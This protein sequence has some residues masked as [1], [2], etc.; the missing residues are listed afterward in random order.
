MTRTNYSTYAVGSKVRGS[1]WIDGKLW[2]W[3]AEVGLFGC[4][5]KKQMTRA[6]FDGRQVGTI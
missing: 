4:L 5:I 1:K 6:M 2:L 3:T